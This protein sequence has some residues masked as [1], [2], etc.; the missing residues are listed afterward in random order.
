MPSSA[1]SNAMLNT[2]MECS[3]TE[4]PVVE[5]PEESSRALVLDVPLG[6]LEGTFHAPISVSASRDDGKCDGHSSL[7]H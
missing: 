1:A 4:S 2:T 6:S 3:Q 7:E 5:V